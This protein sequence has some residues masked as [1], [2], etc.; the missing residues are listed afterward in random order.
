MSSVVVDSYQVDQMF[1][2]LNSR[3]RKKA[4][5]SALISSANILKR[6]TIK[7]YTSKTNLRA[8]SIKTRNK[9]GKEVAKKRDLAKVGWDKNDSAAKVHIMSHYMVKWFEMGTKPRRTKGYRITGYDYSKRV[10]RSWYRTRKGKGS[11][12]GRI[13]PLGLFGKVRDRMERK[14]FDNMSNRLYTSI[15]R[16][17]K[18]Y[19]RN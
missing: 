15:M 5:R 2:A 3:D 10:G 13:Y 14:I 16:I 12:R 7:E 6:E 8:F 4:E 1:K 17:A 9:R 18:K 19:G 11:Y